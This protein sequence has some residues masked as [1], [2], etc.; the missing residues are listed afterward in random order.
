MVSHEKHFLATLEASE[1]AMDKSA[2]DFRE[3]DTSTSG[4]VASATTTGMRL[5]SAHKVSTRAKST[6]DM[7]Q[8]RCTRVQGAMRALLG[9]TLAIPLTAGPS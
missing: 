5:A 6:L 7:L 3:L 4:L 1:A 9:V 2:T 8:V